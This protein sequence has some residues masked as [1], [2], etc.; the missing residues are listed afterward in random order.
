[1]STKPST[2]TSTTHAV[3]N[4]PPPSRFPLKPVLIYKLAVFIGIYFLTKTLFLYCKNQLKLSD[5]HLVVSAELQD[6]TVSFPRLQWR[7]YAI[8]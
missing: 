3:A 8:L 7:S 1:M 5:F 2:A 6:L 4:L